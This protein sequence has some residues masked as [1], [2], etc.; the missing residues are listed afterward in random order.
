M[1]VWWYE[2]MMVWWYDGVW[3]G[4]NKSERAWGMWY[5]W[6]S[7]ASWTQC[8]Y[9]CPLRANSRKRVQGPHF[10][11]ER[12]HV[13]PSANK[14][15]IPTNE[16]F[17]LLHVMSMYKREWW[18]YRSATSSLFIGGTAV[19]RVAFTV[20]RKTS[21]PLPFRRPVVCLRN[22]VTRGRKEGGS[23]TDHVYSQNL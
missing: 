9:W 19:V 3:R 21:Q 8:T 18:V 23:G 4:T 15:L 1:M 7:F 22:K 5:K 16:L 11:Y 10:W 2:G 14:I 20:R 12:G 13:W 6:P 17:V